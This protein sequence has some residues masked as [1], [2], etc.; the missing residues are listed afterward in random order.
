[1]GVDDGG[2]HK[3]LAEDCAALNRYDDARDQAGR[4]LELGRGESTPSSRV[5]F[6]PGRCLS[7]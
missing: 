7:L 2:F 5:I 6:A 4:A 1:M 3:E